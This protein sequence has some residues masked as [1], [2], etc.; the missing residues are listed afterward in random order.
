MVEWDNGNFFFVIG[1][2]VYQP[3]GPLIE[4]HKIAAV[5]A[6]VLPETVRIPSDLKVTYQTRPP[7]SAVLT[8]SSSGSQKGSEKTSEGRHGGSKATPTTSISQR[9]QSKQILHQ[10]YKSATTSSLTVTTSTKQPQPPT[11]IH[12]PL[13][14]NS[15]FSAQGGGSLM[16]GSGGGP[17][18]VGTLTQSA[19]L[20]SHI[21]PSSAIMTSGTAAGNGSLYF[22]Y[23]GSHQSP[24][25]PSKF[26][27]VPPDS[28]RSV[29][30]LCYIIV[31]AGISFLY[32]LC[33]P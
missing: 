19:A 18:A 13:A 22:G 17:M 16:M 3:A 1:S 30:A 25:A 24:F 28:F 29:I 9:S 31:L 20:S 32:F 7:T 4:P 21:N 14:V 5:P 23:G 15:T 33:I 8:V 27:I 10:P 12:S 2:T 26:P 6:G 11:F